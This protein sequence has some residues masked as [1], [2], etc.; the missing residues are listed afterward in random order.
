[1]PMSR[2]RIVAVIDASL[3]FWWRCLRMTSSVNNALT[4]CDST[5]ARRRFLTS[6]IRCSSLIPNRVDVL[7]R[8]SQVG[9]KRRKEYRWILLL[10]AGTGQN[11]PSNG[12]PARECLSICPRRRRSHNR[13]T[14]KQATRRGKK[15]FWFVRTY[16]Y[17]PAQIG[18]SVA[19][20]NLPI[21]RTEW[22]EYI[23]IPSHSG[24][25]K[26]DPM[27]KLSIMSLVVYNLS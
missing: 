9:R 19:V 16:T 17:I 27:D 20:T 22:R 2:R 11:S 13:R 21:Y 24:S 1:M 3:S 15:G 25:P 7:F 6:M 4:R 18:G 14:S 12:D 10:R 26:E 23:L 8:R 5:C